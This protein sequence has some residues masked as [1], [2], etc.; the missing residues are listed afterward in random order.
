M[1]SYLIPNGNLLEP[2]VGKGCLLKGVD[3]DV[4]DSVDVYDIKQEFLNDIKQSGV[5]KFC[6]DFLSVDVSMKYMNIIMNPP[7]IKFQDLSHE[8]RS[9]IKSKFPILAK[10]C[11]DI[12]YAFIIKCID[13]L[14]DNGVMVSITPNS[15]LYNKSAIELRKY[16][17]ENRYIQEIIDFKSEKVFPDASVYCCITI[18]TKTKPDTLVYNGIP[19]QY[20][21][22]CNRNNYMLFTPITDG[23]AQNKTKTLK[24]V[25]KI[26]NG[27]ATLRD[28]VY[29][30]N[31]R[32]FN[33]PC[34][35]EITNSRRVKYAIYPYEDGKIICDDRF[36]SENPQTYVYLEKFRD[37]LGKRDNGRKRYPT[38]YAYGR[39][40]SL[41][42]SDAKRV[43]FIPAFLHPDNICLTIS[44]P[45]I[46]QTCLCI[47]PNND[48][49][50]EAIYS[51]IMS[52]STYL[53]DV[54][55]KRSGGWVNITTRTLYSIPFVSNIC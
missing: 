54:S 42:L 48:D 7:Y 18:F 20:T 21:D 34:W 44:K 38:W 1:C 22:I 52:N 28:K 31:T 32:L 6:G 41:H 30:H 33:E 49:D 55:S 53:G 24:N 29:I 43:I 10:G 23:H 36:K 3:L 9:F 5:N 47:E 45:M 27:I 25:C 16:L 19:I 40:Q 50:I 51:A 8:Y 2:S 14:R 4:Y 39:S 12:Y 11:I 15:F 13:L 35:Q 46:Y 17:F 37:E 26:S